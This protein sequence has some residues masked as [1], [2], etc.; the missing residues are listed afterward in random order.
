[1]LAAKWLETRLDQAWSWHDRLMASARFRQWA[2]RFPLTK[3]VASR[4]ARALFD[5]TAGFVYSQVLLACVELELF[6]LLADGPMPADTLAQRLNLPEEAAVQ[7]LEAAEALGLTRRR[8][9]RWALGRLG[10]VMVNDT[11]ITAM[12]R[13]HAM[14]YRDL[15]D[16]VALLR[17]DRG[18][19]ALAAYWPYSGAAQPDSVSAEAAAPYTRLMAASQPMISAEVLQ[20]HDFAPHTC[21]LDVGGGDGSFL[22]AIGEAHPALRL[23]LFDL[24]AV[25]ELARPRFAAMAARVGLHGGD[26]HTLSLPKGADSLSFVRVL[27]DHDDAAVR[28]MLRAAHAALPPGGTLLVAEPMA[29]AV[30]AEAMGAAYFGL[31]LRAMGTGRPRRPA[32]LM[33]MIT[34]AGFQGAR[35]VTTATPLVTQLVVAK[36]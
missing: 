12:V 35:L 3:P 2:A 8:G 17:G 6:T 33:A 7:L 5:L 1:M 31:Y 29:G 28:R 25:V 30:G 14:L 23:M 36:S 13:H 18:G 20:A 16:P 19:G 10:A 21:L 27:H 11:A 34:E 22:R 15:A 24:P 32:E 4:R 9:Q 26:F